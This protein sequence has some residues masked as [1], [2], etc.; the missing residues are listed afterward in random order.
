MDFPEHKIA[1][2]PLEWITFSRNLQLW[3]EKSSAAGYGE[4]LS[5][6]IF[7]RK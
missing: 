5:R 7:I 4:K 2:Q 1:T 6:K 3:W